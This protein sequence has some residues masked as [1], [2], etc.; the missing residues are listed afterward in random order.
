MGPT[1]GAEAP[2]QPGEP[3]NPD[4]LDAGD[5]VEGFGDTKHRNVIAYSSLKKLGA[6]HEQG[7]ESA[8]PA[9]EYAT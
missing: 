3:D 6:L 2:D 9:P 5:V 7:T 4:V 8:R 1:P